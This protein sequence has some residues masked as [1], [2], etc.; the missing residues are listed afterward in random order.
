MIDTA[1]DGALR[2]LKHWEDHPE[3]QPRLLLSVAEID[4]ADAGAD[5][6]V[7]LTVATAA[8]I[9]QPAMVKELCR[10]RHMPRV[11]LYRA[12]NRAMKPALELDG[13]VLEFLGLHPCETAAELA[14]AV[15]RSMREAGFAATP[16]EAQGLWQQT[17]SEP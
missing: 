17:S 8:G 11:A 16:L 3:K 7:A 1:L 6:W 9:P 12:M 13:R 5:A 10:L 14:R 2:A 15:A 4:A